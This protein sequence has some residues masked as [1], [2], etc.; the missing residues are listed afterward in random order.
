MK[1]EIDG[2]WK[3]GKRR[4]EVCHRWCCIDHYHCIY[5]MCLDA[6]GCFPPANKPADRDD[7]V[8]AAAEYK[9]EPDL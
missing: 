5:E 1:C 3:K 7:I 8:E 9:Y 6:K 2:C 4:C